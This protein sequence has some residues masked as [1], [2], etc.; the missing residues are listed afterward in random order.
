MMELCEI[1]SFLIHPLIGVLFFS[2]FTE[3]M[4]TVNLCEIENGYFINGLNIGCGRIICTF[5]SLPEYGS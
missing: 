3:I 5:C 4:L 1:I 2:V